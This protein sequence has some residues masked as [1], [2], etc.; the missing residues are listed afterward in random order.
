MAGGAEGNPLSRVRD[1]RDISVV[2]ADELVDIDQVIRDGDSACSLVH[3]RILPR[4]VECWLVGGR[5]RR[6]GGSG[7]DAQ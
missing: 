1:I 6:A 3:N 4:F 5:R 7:A 2:R